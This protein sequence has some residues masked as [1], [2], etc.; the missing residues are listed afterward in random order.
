MVRKEAGTL[1]LMGE[2]GQPVYVDRAAWRGEPPEVPGMVFCDDME[3]LYARKL[4]TSNAGHALLAYL[5]ARRGCEFIHD[6]AEVP[7]LRRHLCEL[8]DVARRALARRYGDE[9]AIRA[10]VERLL[11]CRFPNRDL[12]D[13]VARVAR[14]PL[15]KLGPEERLVGLARLL[16]SSGLPTEPVSRAIGAALHYFDPGDAQS[17][18]LRGLLA[19]DG[20]RGV[21][22][23]VCGL[24]GDEA[25]FHECLR[26]YASV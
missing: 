4:F 23:S 21:L 14:D 17:V 15:R 7:E 24:D 20:P 26:F 5:G 19:R 8:L 6:A 2:E 13:P 9:A 22:R 18:R 3:P 10:H 1:D 16:Q 12:A 25:C 11:T